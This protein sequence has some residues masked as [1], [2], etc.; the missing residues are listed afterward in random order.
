MRYLAI[1]LFLTSFQPTLYAQDLS[2]SAFLERQSKA[3]KMDYTL[4]LESIEVEVHI[5]EPNYDLKGHYRADKSGKMRIDIYAG[6]KIV[7][8]EAL[9]SWEDGWQQFG[10]G[11]EI[12][13]LSPE[14]LKALAK[15]I[16]SNLFSLTEL[17][18]LGYQLAFKGKT[19][20]RGVE[21]WALD[22]THPAGDL[23]RWLFDTETYLQAASLEENALHPDM[24]PTIVP[25]IS[26]YSDYRNLDGYLRAAKQRRFNLKTGDLMQETTVLDTTIN[27]EITPS[28]YAKP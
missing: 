16:H 22:I 19:N 5:K 10:P 15:G 8:S 6:D 2:L 23:E 21:Y 18:G 7:F 24:D 14:G 1:L 28:T 11:T 26:Y 25:Q 17:Q 4:P 3:S 9:I 12:K 13:A 20:V 27:P